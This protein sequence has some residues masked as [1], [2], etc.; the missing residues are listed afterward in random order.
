MQAVP[1]KSYNYCA[2]G[3]P[4]TQPVFTLKATSCRHTQTQTRP[5]SQENE[6]LRTL[7]Y[8]TKHRVTD[9]ITTTA[10]R[11]CFSIF[12][13]QRP[14]KIAPPNEDAGGGESAVPFWY[15]AGDVS[16]PPSSNI[17]EIR[18][19]S[20]TPF[21]NISCRLLMLWSRNVTCRAV[22][23]A[24]LRMFRALCGEALVRLEANAIVSYVV[25]TITSALSV[26]LM[27]IYIYF[28]I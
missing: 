12:Y 16:E 14:M 10:L 3:P 19:S 15:D 25:D 1:I 5:P 13:S 4:R 21:V 20:F 27:L 7:L 6:Y 22:N 11:P 9:N 28:G 17:H 2:A 18:E 23:R 8:Q 24:T 26:N